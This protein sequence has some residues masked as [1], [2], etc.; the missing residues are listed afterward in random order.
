MTER[1]HFPCS[2]TGL[3]RLRLISA[4]IALAFV[5][6][7]LPMVFRHIVNQLPFRVF[8]Q[9]CV[10]PRKSN[11]SG[12]LSPRSARFP[13]A[14]RPNS[15]S[16]V[17]PWYIPSPNFPSRSRNACR[18]L[19]ASS[20]YSNPMTNARYPPLACQC[21]SAL[22]SVLRRCLTPQ[23]RTRQDYGHRPS[24]A[25]P[26]AFCPTDTAGVSR[27][28]NIECPHML[29]VSDSA[30][31]VCGSLLLAVIPCCLPFHTTR[32]VPRKGDFAAQWLACVFPCQRFTCGLA[33]ACK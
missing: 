30:G 19:S 11:V 2:G 24:P 14:N 5:R 3:C 13:S 29:R 4:P 8:E 7:R 23:R 1:I 28:S 26:P 31:P 21:C 27:F 9:M 16:L 22:S 33:A 18:N 20:R 17:F 32:S 25:D 12:L 10:N 6:S 15:M